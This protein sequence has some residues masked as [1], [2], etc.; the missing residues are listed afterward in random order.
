MTS[1]SALTGAASFRMNSMEN[2]MPQFRD[3]SVAEY[4][5]LIVA[6]I[7]RQF[8]QYTNISIEYHDPD[9]RDPFERQWSL[10]IDSLEAYAEFD[11]DLDDYTIYVSGPDVP[12]ISI[13][14]DVIDT[15]FV[16]TL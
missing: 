12:S 4:N 10:E 13:K 8:P 11:P 5:D 14:L 9:H 7:R 1:G 15:R 2:E 3:L 16:T 6:D